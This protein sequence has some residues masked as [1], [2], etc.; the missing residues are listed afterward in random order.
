MRDLDL[1]HYT[2]AEA[3]P[4]VEGLV[5]LYLRVYPDGG[6]FHSEDRY[7]RQLSTHME[8]HGWSLVTAT[9]DGELIGYIYGFPLPAETGWWAGLEE[10]VP[11]GFTEETGR[12]TFA[13]SELLVHPRRRRQGV[14]RALHDQLVGRRAEERATLLV[15]PDNTVARR[16]YDSW[17][18]RYVTHLTPSW[19]NAPRFMVLVSTVPQSG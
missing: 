15:D 18:W 6:E 2:A 13:V 4:L 12:R 9:A 16:A 14:A 10:P 19:E 5:D 1:R 8:R 11:T 3:M 17:G 7:R